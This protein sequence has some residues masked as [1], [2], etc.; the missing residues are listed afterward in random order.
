MPEIPLATARNARA[1]LMWGTPPEKV[2]ESLLAKDV[3]EA[4]AAVLI[5]SVMVERAETIR[6]EGKKKLIYG[7]L[8]VA[9]PIAYYGVSVLIG[10]LAIKLLAGLCVLGVVGI[11]KISVGASM[12]LK[13][14]SHTGDLSNL[15][16]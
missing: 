16:G 4:D 15:N 7:I 12:I 2:R 6:A 5:E 11:Y 10:I 8:G 1:E 14:R 3:T 13:P 9:A